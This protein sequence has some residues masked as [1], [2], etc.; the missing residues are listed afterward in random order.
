MTL[1]RAA[2]RPARRHR[3]VQRR[4]DPS[5]RR[6]ADP[7]LRGRRH[8]GRPSLH[9]AAHAAPRRARRRTARAS[10]ST[11]SARRSTASSTA[12]TSSGSASDERRVRADVPR[13]DPRPLQGATEPRAA[14]AVRREGRGAEPAVRRRGHRLAALRRGRRDRGGR[15][16]GPGL[17]DQP[18]R[19]VD[20]HRPRARPHRVGGRGDAEGRAP[21]GDRDPSHPGP[22]QVRAARA[23]RPQGRAP[24]RQGHR[25][26]PRSGAPRRATITLG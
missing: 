25:R 1:L 10:T 15:L 16:R 21:R 20:A 22:A 19:D 23:R 11:R 8:P 9:A 4:R 17:R 7:R 3:L 24:P 6:G 26:S 14:R 2:G 13:G 18:G 5:A 12:S